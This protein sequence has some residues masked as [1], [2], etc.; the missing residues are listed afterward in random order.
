MA[1]LLAEQKFHG[2]K[3]RLQEEMVR[4]IRAVRAGQDEGAYLDPSDF[5]AV[6]LA[7][8]DDDP[9][10]SLIGA[11]RAVA[12]CQKQTEALLDDP[13]VWGGVERVAKALYRR[14]CLSP[15]AVKQLLGDAFL[16][17]AMT[18]VVVVALAGWSILLPAAA[19]PLPVPKVGQCPSGYPESGGYCAPTSDR[20][21]AAVP[22]RGQCPSG[23]TQSGNYCV[24]TRRR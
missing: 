7:L 15:R 19:E 11:R 16:G 9:A 3:W 2:L 23:W 21:P 6:A 14:R 12:Y 8:L 1:G 22:K 24:E 5:R 20:A 10:I 13:C 17:G 18:R 4:E